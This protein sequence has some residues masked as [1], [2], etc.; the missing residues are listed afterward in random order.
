MVPSSSRLQTDKGFYFYYSL[1]D[2]DVT[3]ETFYDLITTD[4]PTERASV[5]INANP[6]SVDNYFQ[7]KQN[8]KVGVSL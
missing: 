1:F 6:K 7:R 8:L 2:N 5:R 3:N 4:I